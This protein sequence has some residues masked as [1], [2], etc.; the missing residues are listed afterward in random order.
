MRHEVVFG[1]EEWGMD[2]EPAR[3][4]FDPVGSRA[5]QMRKVQAS[6]AAARRRR[7]TRANSARPTSVVVAA[8]GRR[9]KQTRV[10]T[11]RPAPSR[12]PARTRPWPPDAVAAHGAA[13]LERRARRLRCCRRVG[14]LLDRAPM[15]AMRRVS[16]LG[17]AG[18]GQEGGRGVGGHGD[19]AAGS[20]RSGG[21]GLAGWRP[22]RTGSVGPGRRRRGASRWWHRGAALAD[23]GPQGRARGS[24]LRRRSQL[25]REVRGPGRVLR[26]SE[27][28]E[29]GQGRAAPER[30]LTYRRPRP[31]RDPNPAFT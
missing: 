8:A 21:A 3:V 28:Y 26:T 18:E 5:R 2:R 16:E 22:G 7:L 31:E 14:G 6:R 29:E 12:A 1:R 17:G 15:S 19:Q 27:G 11:G 10:P 13:G 24:A 4:L 20:V 9:S 30:V 23:R 25:A